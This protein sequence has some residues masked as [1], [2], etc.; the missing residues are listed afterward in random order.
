MQFKYKLGEEMATSSFDKDFIISDPQS[1]ERLIEA[2]EKPTVI[3][4]PKK[5]LEKERLEEQDLLCR[6][7]TYFDSLKF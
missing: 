3:N 5:D 6:F 1:V 7:S 4:L 2:L